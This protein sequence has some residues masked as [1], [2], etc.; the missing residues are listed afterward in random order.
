MLGET[1][2]CA[3]NRRDRAVALKAHADRLCQA[4]HGI[5]RIHT[6][7]GSACRTYFFLIL[8]KLFNSHLAGCDRSYRFKHGGKASLSPVDPSRQHRSAGYKDRRDINARRCH[9][10]A[11]D[12]LVTVGDHDKSVKTVGSCHTLGGIRDQVS[13][14]QG[15]LHSDVSHRDAVAN[16][17]RGKYNRHA[18]CHCNAELD[19][20][21]DLIEIHM[22]G[23]DLIVGADDS[24]HRASSL[25][26]RIAESIEETSVRCLGDTL[27]YAV[28]FHFISFPSLYSSGISR[29]DISR[30]TTMY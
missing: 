30:F 6:G 23:Y 22:S 13:C 5:C 19:S 17:D 15:I 18:A 9:Q 3:V 4:V 21:R 11:G 26:F 10:K 24:D 1:D 7:A 20:L 12:V 2:P 16:S 27:F 8:G 25:L 14:D 29:E 28:T